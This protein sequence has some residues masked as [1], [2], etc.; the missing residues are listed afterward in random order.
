M[1]PATTRP[2]EPGSGDRRRLA[3]AGAALSAVAAV[4]VAAFVPPLGGGTD[5]LPPFA[6]PPAPATP[7]AEAETASST[8]R[9]ATRGPVDP[10]TA[11]RV[12]ACLALPGVRHT[13]KPS[14]PPVHGVDV[15]GHGETE[16]F[17]TCV[18]A[19]AGD[20]VTLT[21]HRLPPL[22]TQADI[23]AFVESCAWG[24]TP[25]PVAGYVGATQEQALAPGRN[26]RILG[27]DGICNPGSPVP[28]PTV[29]DV[30]IADGVVVWAGHLPFPD[31]PEPAAPPA[32]PA[33]RSV[34]WTGASVCLLGA[35]DQLCRDL[36]ALEA[37]ELQTVLGR[38][39]LDTTGGATDCGPDDR[40]YTV[41]FRHPAVRATLTTVPLTCAPVTVSGGR[42]RLDGRSRDQVK[43]AYDG[44]VPAGTAAAVDR[45]VSGQERHRAPEL[46]GLTEDGLEALLGDGTGL[47][48]IGRDGDCV[49]ERRDLRPERVDVLLE[50]GRVVWASRS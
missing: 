40:V 28:D 12:E 20:G 31:R 48:V 21:E 29:V 24:R 34:A 23:A 17:A 49:A 44:A 8:V 18:R 9:Y 42:Y 15:T 25:T 26:S 50:D 39:V 45:C 46:L 37:R 33:P 30:V 6:A 13:D 41:R 2:D 7:V 14:V 35:G 19:L 36:G 11:E 43:R 4:A 27:R 32:V 5:E 22:D 1:R 38:A 47:R 16:A 3:T 10:G